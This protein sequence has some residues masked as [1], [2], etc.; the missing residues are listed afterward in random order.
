M[1][2]EMADYQQICTSKKLSCPKSPT[3]NCWQTGILNRQSSIVRCRSKKK[4]SLQIILRSQSS[5]VR[6][7]W[8]TGIQFGQF[9]LGQISYVNVFQQQRSLFGICISIVFSSRYR[10]QLTDILQ[11]VRFRRHCRARWSLVHVPFFFFTLNTAI[12]TNFCPN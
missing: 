11:I 5:I 10:S 4:N 12:E 1:W 8:P 3:W 2:L 9:Q 7:G 6:M